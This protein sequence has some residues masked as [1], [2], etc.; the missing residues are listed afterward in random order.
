MNASASTYKSMRDA[1]L[2]FIIYGLDWYWESATSYV[3][4]ICYIL[5][6]SMKYRGENCTIKPSIHVGS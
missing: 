5:S 4:I 1:F 2:S 3:L 6:W